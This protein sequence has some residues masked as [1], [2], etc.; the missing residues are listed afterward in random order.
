MPQTSAREHAGKIF[1]KKIYVGED[2][3]LT[4][5]G[6]A[7]T[8]TAA[9]LNT[10]AGASAESAT[11]IQGGFATITGSGTVTSTLATLSSVVAVL[12]ADAALTG[13]YVTA[14]KSGLTIT[15][16]VWK[17]TSNADPTPIAS[18]TAVQVNWI[19]TGT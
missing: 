10:V 9:D 11:K 8:A 2:G 3:G 1:A 15:L 5:N 7:V 19:A 4:I 18:T 16:K 17:P 14:T 12:G 6:T 13:T